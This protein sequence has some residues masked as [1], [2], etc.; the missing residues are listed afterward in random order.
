MAKPSPKGAGSA[1]KHRGDGAAKL[2]QRSQGGRA[3]SRRWQGEPCAHHQAGTTRF[4]VKW[5]YRTLPRYVSGAVSQLEVFLP[6]PARPPCWG[7]F[8]TAQAIN[9]FLCFF[10]GNAPPNQARPGCGR[11]SP[12][13]R[14]A[15]P[16]GAEENFVARGPGRPGVGQG[17][18]MGAGTAPSTKGAAAGPAW[19]TVSVLPRSQRI[20]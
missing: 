4:V 11:K 2:L 8:T 20:L 6:R 17:R 16:A 10:F 5:E 13:P 15:R 9:H 14:L 19:P 1:G 18:A 7:G 12:L 3:N